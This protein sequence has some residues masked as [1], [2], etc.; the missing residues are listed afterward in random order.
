M[1]CGEKKKQKKIKT[2]NENIELRLMLPNMKEAKEEKIKIA[3][4]SQKNRLESNDDVHI[5]EAGAQN[6]QFENKT[7]LKRR[8]KLI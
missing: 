7:V 6:P 1:E 3:K 8:F 2:M 5:L 4:K